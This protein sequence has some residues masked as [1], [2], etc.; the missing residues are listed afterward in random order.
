MA[1]IILQ[2]QI[3]VINGNQDNIVVPRIKMK[4][5]REPQHADSPNTTVEE[6]PSDKVDERV[7]E[8][9]AHLPADH[10]CC[11]CEK[12]EKRLACLPCGHLVACTTCGQTLRICPICH[13]HIDAFVRVYL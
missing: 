13:R 11:I 12:E 1:C 2:K 8:K 4:S 5:V 7:P 3:E 9:T 10:P 6:V